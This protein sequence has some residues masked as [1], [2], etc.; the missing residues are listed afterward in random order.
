MLL[1]IKCLITKFL[2]N[3]FFVS[4]DSFRSIIFLKVDNLSE[5]SIIENNNFEI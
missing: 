5:F 2:I 3:Y 1:Y 4:N